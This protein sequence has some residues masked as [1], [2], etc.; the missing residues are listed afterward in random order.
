MHL[1]SFSVSGFRSLTN[2]TDIP[3]SAPTILAG[4]NDGGKTAVLAAL[5]FLVGAYSMVEDDRTYIARTH[6]NGRGADAAQRHEETEVVGIFTL[7]K[8]EQ[9]A[10][11]LPPRLRIRRYVGEDLI[12]HFECWLPI[13]DDDRLRDLSVHKVPELKELAKEFGISPVPQLR[14]DLEEAL[15]VY[16][17]EH[18]GP[19]GWVGAPSGLASRMPQVVAFSG[20]KPA[21]DSV[22]S[23]LQGRFQA[24]MADES[25]QGRLQMIEAEVKDRL[26]IDAKSLCDHIQTRCPDFTDV[27]VEPEVSFTHGFRA[28]RLRLARSSGEH[29]GL[30]RSGQGSARRV[31]LAVWEWTSELLS[32]QK[33]VEPTVAQ[34]DDGSATPP[35]TQTIIVYDEPDTHLDYGHQRQIMQLIREQSSLPDVSVMVATHSMNLIDGV[36]I[37]DVVNLKLQQGRTVME[38]LGASDHDSIDKHL[39]QIAAA[40]GLRNSV[41]L[42]ERCFLAVEGPSEQRAIPLLFRLSEGMSLQSAGIAL[43]AC[44]NNEGALHLARYLVEHGRSVMVAVDADSRTAGRGMF[45]EDRLRQ[46]FGAKTS[47]IVKMIGE[48]E[49]FNEF[50]ELFHDDLWASV[51]NEIW[52]RNK[53][54]WR[55]EDFKA[56]RGEG[57][58][59]ADVQ[60]MLQEQSDQGPGGKPD[61]MFQLALALTEPSQVPDQLR[62][63]FKELRLRAA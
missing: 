29:V 16:A 40:V 42:H 53:S 17:A 48:P 28:A 45:K 14:A 22:R 39:Q 26:Q 4:H 56:L 23:V 31:A 1:S 59:S 62:D 51:A 60:R 46:T 41:L 54:S 13:P 11:K 32:S 5:Q 63:I 18:S 25:L 49:K 15:R 36:D 20:H 35:R 43:W 52:P 47:Q 33:S 7:D 3:V 8:W 9:E 12:P 10:F 58:F 19:A 27:F 50:E 6:G 2:V 57:K 38:R 34:D 61:M 30:E 24:H 44:C 55:A 37:S 21:E